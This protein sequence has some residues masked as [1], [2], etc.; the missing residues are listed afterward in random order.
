MSPLFL[1]A[2]L[3]LQQSAPLFHETDIGCV[4][5]FAVAVEAKALGS[6][7]ALADPELDERAFAHMSTVGERIRGLPDGQREEAVA[8]FDARVKEARE[9][10][11]GA[12]DKA[13]YLRGEVERC[14]PTFDAAL[15]DTAERLSIP[16]AQLPIAYLRCTVVYAMFHGVA[17]RRESAHGQYGARMGRMFSELYAASRFPGTMSEE[18]KAEIWQRDYREVEAAWDNASR[19]APDDRQR[20]LLLAMSPGRR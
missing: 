8:R 15:A 14:R 13:T 18:R 12:K 6:A 20:C 16:A 1:S 19:E 2:A 7:A 3:A 17:Y 4:A 5:A 11:A 10:A 9:A